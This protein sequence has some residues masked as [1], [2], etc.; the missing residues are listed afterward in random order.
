MARRKLTI[1]VT[2][3]DRKLGVP[4]EA[5]MARSL[6]VGTVTDRASQWHGRVTA[7]RPE[8]RL[9]DLYKGESWAQAKQ[10]ADTAAKAGF[11]AELL[12]A[13]AGLGL[14]SVN[15]MGPAYA[16]TFARGH[17]DSVAASAADAVLWWSRLPHT[18]APRH[19]VPSIWVLS[20]SYALAMRDQLSNLDPVTSLVFGGASDTP[21]S[22][23]IRSDRNLRAAL[24]GTVTSLNTRMAIRWLEIAD[25]LAPTSAQAR[26][27]WAA[28]A[29]DAQKPEQY[30]RR[31]LPDTT[32]RT[33]IKEMLGRQ[34][35]LS[36]TVA[37]KN[38]RASGIACEQRRFSGLFEEAC[39][40]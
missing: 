29:R 25:D 20:E 27:A 24:G 15:D 22:L 32:I 36:K 33:L 8:T 31:P 4:S 14:R 37:L 9:L 11:D 5:M 17:Q 18:A 6:P 13:S 39:K 34:P 12:V 35:E 38:L 21:E 10:L 23:R 19:D 26:H 28:W 3:T 16:A 2:C 7:A 40:A 30:D 1:V